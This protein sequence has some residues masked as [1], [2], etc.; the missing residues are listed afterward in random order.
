MKD[1]IK[2]FLPQWFINYFYHLP[3]AF[4]ANII[5]GFPSHGIKNIGVTGT[6]GKTTTVNMVYQI[7]KASG[8]KV[9]MVST[10]NAV[11]GGK[12]M[13]TG[14]HVTSPDPFLVQKLIRQAVS[15]GSEYIILEVTSHALN[16]FRF[17]GIK[18]DIAVVTNITHE[19]LDYHGTWTNYFNTKAKL[20][21]DTDIAVINRDEKYF[22]KLSHI[23]NRTCKVISF[24]R[25]KNAEF[26][27]ENFPLKLKVPGVFNILNG[28][29]AASVCRALGIDNKSIKHALESFE[30]LPGR[31]EEVKNNM[32]VRIIIDFAHT[33]NGLQNVLET[34]R[35]QALPGKLISLIGAEGERDIKKRPIMGEIAQKLSNIVI[36]T[37]VDPRGKIREINK[38]IKKGALKSGA[39]SGKNFYIVPDRE[40]AINFAIKQLAKKGD[41]IGIFGK[42][43]ETSMNLDGKKE[44][45]WLDKDKVE[46]ALNGK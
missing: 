16:Q 17:W 43:H 37:S 46:K 21:K 31:M 36:V 39:K 23:T 20:I 1:F 44:I 26:N 38:Q 32:G 4:L 13:E 6:D 18:W 30:S 3:V 42:G 33:P 35:S 28:L 27:I 40:K 7:L 25:S 15:R 8:K 34:L 22:P 12:V 2:H 19:H 10:I 29:A 5:Y 41:T 11:I 45:P 24:G 14:F 9:S